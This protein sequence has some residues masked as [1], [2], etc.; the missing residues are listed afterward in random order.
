VAAYLIADISVHDPEK[1]MEYVDQVPAF[2]EKHG[3]HYRIRGGAPR[4]QEGDWEPPRLVIIEFPSRDHAMA[5][6]NDPGYQPVAA[7]RHASAS[8]NLVVADGVGESP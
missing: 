2:V 6:L 8:T 3:G 5:F 7:I 4:C 1:F